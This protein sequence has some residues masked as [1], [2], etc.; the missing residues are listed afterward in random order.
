MTSEFQKF[1][2][3]LEFTYEAEIFPEDPSDLG[4]LELIEA[5]DLADYFSFYLEDTLNKG[6]FKNLRLEAV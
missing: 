5:D 3:T 4:Q 6:E 2:G 1:R